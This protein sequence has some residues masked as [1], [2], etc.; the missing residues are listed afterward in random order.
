MIVNE[1]FAKPDK[2]MVIPNQVDIDLFQPFEKKEIKIRAEYKISDDT[3]IIGSIGRFIKRSKG[4]EICFQVF[5][6][7]LKNHPKVQSLFYVAMGKKEGFYNSGYQGFRDRKRCY[8]YRAQDG[9]G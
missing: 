6:K 5:A 7:V 2:I 8:N 3:I 9:Y 4:F 1:N